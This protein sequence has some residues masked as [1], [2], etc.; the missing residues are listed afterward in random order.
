M[1]ATT[2]EYSVPGT[3]RRNALDVYVVGVIGLATAL[4]AI[5][6]VSD[7]TDADPRARWLPIGLFVVLLVLGETR[8]WFQFG[9]GGEVTPSWAF[10]FSIVLLGAPTVAAVAI[11]G[12]TLLVDLNDRRGWQKSLFNVAQVIVSL[13]A[14]ALVLRS[15]GVIGPMTA[16]GSIDVTEAIGVMAA[17]AIVF[18]TNG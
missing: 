4:L 7:V 18:V 10:A 8:T 13:T 9:D 14:G 5:T 17:G 15:F 12:C 6:L 1:T 11:G 16:S 2:A 3:N